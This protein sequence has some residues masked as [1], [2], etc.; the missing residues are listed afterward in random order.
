[1][2][3]FWIGM[4]L[5]AGAAAL[6]KIKS[7]VIEGVAALIAIGGVILVAMGMELG[8][9]A[10]SSSS[11]MAMAVIGWAFLFSPVKDKEVF[12]GRIVGA[13]LI[14]IGVGASA[15]MAGNPDASGLW[16]ALTVVW[17]AIKS[18]FSALGRALGLA[19]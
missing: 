9:R 19:T 13:V 18:G 15:V 17:E 8:E 4:L 16:E 6:F 1:M 12:L 14:A 10:T 3:Q 2:D 7:L 5:V 11:F